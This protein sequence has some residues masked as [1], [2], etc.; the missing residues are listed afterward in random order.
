MESL[1]TTSDSDYLY[2]FSQFKYDSHYNQSLF[3]QLYYTIF[4]GRV[5]R[6]ES[7]RKEDI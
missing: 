1:I 6:E 5:G 2:L 3:C 7:E 4:N